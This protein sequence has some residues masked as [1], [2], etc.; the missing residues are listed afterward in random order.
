MINIQNNLISMLS[1]QPSA[2]IA[3]STASPVGNAAAAAIA[4]AANDEPG[5][6]EATLAQHLPSDEA[7]AKL[8]E[9]ARKAA[10]RQMLPEPE[11][12][13][14]AIFAAMLQAGVLTQEMPA[15]VSTVSADR[16][17]VAAVA[18]AA[19]GAKAAATTATA[20]IAT[21]T[22]ANTAAT[23]TAT[24]ANTAAAAIAAAATTEAATTTNVAETAA[25][26]AAAVPTPTTP[27]VPTVDTAASIPVATAVDQLLTVVPVASASVQQSAGTSG[28]G[29][30]AQLLTLVP[31][32]L[33]SVQQSAGTSGARVEA[34]RPAQVQAKFEPVQVEASTMSV[35]APLPVAVTVD[36]SPVLVPQRNALPTQA[37]S[38]ASMSLPAG[39]TMVFVPAEAKVPQQ[40]AA[41]IAAVAAAPA[42]PVEAKQLANPVAT[43][44]AP[45]TVSSVAAVAQPAMAVEEA[46]VSL[47]AQVARPA[48]HAEVSVQVQRV[49]VNGGEGQAA[50]VAALVE[51]SAMDSN[52]G[53]AD[54][55]Q[56]GRSDARQSKDDMAPAGLPAGL[57]VQ[58][59]AAANQP[60]LAPAEAALPALKADV[61]A[62]SNPDVLAAGNGMPG[63]LQMQLQTETM[64]PLTLDM[65]M[66]GNGQAHLVVHAAS[67]TLRQ[68]LDGRR[69]QLVDTMQ[70]L[71][72]ALQVD[73]GRGGR[74]ST[75]EDR[76]QA[77]A[78]AAGPDKDVPTASATAA[79]TLP[80]SK[81]QAGTSRLNFYA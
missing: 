37:A 36:S 28:A 7:A 70:G 46:S 73:V 19:I 32:A 8:L 60:A 64:G 23:A 3:A 72:L 27:A 65:K 14:A 51:S 30:E 76:N 42:K 17:A 56:Q 16:P 41:E 71:G 38:Q 57:L 55:P 44:P 54:L 74:P 52:P 50:V 53:N 75:S 62:I 20:A 1:P 6:F 59:Q 31:V 63:R 18:T 43:L 33:A 13:Q 4:M 26:A 34:Q 40:L 15:A 47:A 68:S 22:S 48:G 81:P 66:D 80:R 77:E 79:I 61:V 29:V 49:P 58:Q 35:A 10:K 25:K 69:D 39:M 67:E 24:A 2:G 45:P 5:G 11:A 21:A 78:Q 9:T 12:E